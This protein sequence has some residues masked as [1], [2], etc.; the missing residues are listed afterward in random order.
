MKPSDL[1]TPEPS[2]AVD[3][4]DRLTV[5]NERLVAR[6][7]DLRDKILAVSESDGQLRRRFATSKA[8]QGQFSSEAAYLAFM[9]EEARVVRTPAFQRQ[10]AAEMYCEPF[11]EK[12]TAY[13]RE[14]NVSQAE[15]VK[16]CAG[17][18]PDLCAKMTG[19]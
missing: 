8:L 10:L 18:Y 6:V 3:L 12:V 14:H 11:M 13:E 19:R 17:L 5:E 15:A 4:E 9:H 1:N 7:A 2:T 16:A